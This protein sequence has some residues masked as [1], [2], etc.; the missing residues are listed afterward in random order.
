MIAITEPKTEKPLNEERPRL[1][2]YIPLVNHMV[3]TF[4]RMGL[5]MGPVTLLTV[6]GR[7]TGKTR[8]NPVGF[9]R[10]KGRQYLFSTF[11]SVNWVRNLRAARI[12]TVR[13]GLH[14]MKVVPIELSPEDAVPV[15]KEVIAPA[16]QGLGGMIFRDH[17]P[18][19]P[20]APLSD[21]IIEA[22]KHPVFELRPIVEN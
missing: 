8:R 20:D 2:F 14:S 4:L 6:K 22:R 9:F 3:R 13:K 16:F 17:M 10:L 12:A 1:P 15:L 7:N 21:F 5:P 19:K 18:L 11:G